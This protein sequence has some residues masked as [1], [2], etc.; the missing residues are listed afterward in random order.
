MV[1]N[2]ANSRLVTIVTDDIA[3]NH[4][5]D[6]VK[7]TQA[8]PKSMAFTKET[9]IGAKNSCIN[10]VKDR[11]SIDWQQLSVSVWLWALQGPLKHLL[12]LPTLDETFKANN[13]DL[14]SHDDNS[15]TTNSL[16]SNEACKS[17]ALYWHKALQYDTSD[18][19][20]CEASRTIA[21][22]QMVAAANVLKYLTPEAAEGMG[23]RELCSLLRTLLW[24]VTH[25][26]IVFQ[27]LTLL[28]IY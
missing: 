1:D 2:S 3:A 7:R 10:D 23:D 6:T 20:I 19:I 22:R 13:K 26:Y 27:N 15:H 11:K 24:L 8:S 5:Y 12:L 16:E 25:R 17:M 14:S 4:S 21:R 18:V 9:H 28:F